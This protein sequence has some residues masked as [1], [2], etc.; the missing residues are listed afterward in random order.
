MDSLVGRD[1]DE[2]RID[3]DVELAELESSEADSVGG[4]SLHSKRKQE[5]A[6]QQDDDDMY[7]GGSSS[8]GSGFQADGHE[9][10]TAFKKMARARAWAALDRSHLHQAGESST[11]GLPNVFQASP[12][13]T[14][15]VIPNIFR[16]SSS[17]PSGS[18]F[19]TSSAT[20]ADDTPIHEPP[21]LG[22]SSHLAIGSNRE[23]PATPTARTRAVDAGPPS[24]LSR[25]N[26]G[27]REVALPGIRLFGRD[28][29]IPPWIE[30]VTNREPMQT[31]LEGGSSLG[32]TNRSLHMSRV[33]PRKQKQ[34]DDIMGEE[35]D[36]TG[37]S[38]AALNNGMSQED[39]GQH[40]KEMSAE[41]QLEQLKTSLASSSME[42]EKKEQILARWKRDLQK[43]RME[44]EMEE[45][46][47][48]Y[49][50]SS[51]SAEVESVEQDPGTGAA[52]IKQLEQGQFEVLTSAEELEG[53]SWIFEG[54]R[55]GYP[56]RIAR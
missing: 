21:P 38:N 33:K 9:Q 14:G 13:S 42:P 19:Q 15:S 55:V 31:E 16:T 34:G 41:E 6:F 4:S 10:P 35:L 43:Q 53:R 39:A 50:A 54:P 47:E 49:E 40:G 48:Y 25:I 2:S 32:F 44:N 36:L 30:G 45:E 11:A 18:I 56:Q 51:F 24:L 7:I 37:R 26:A 17:T 27:R 28:N 5:D 3:P 22:R 8:S 29:E 1:G 23:Y 52:T 20:P 46:L 12:L